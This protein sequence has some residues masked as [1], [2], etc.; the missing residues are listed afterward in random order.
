MNLI[1]SRFLLAII[2]ISMALREHAVCSKTTKNFGSV[3]DGPMSREFNQP[4]DRDNAYPYIDHKQQYGIRF[5][6]NKEIDQKFN[7]EYDDLQLEIDST[8]PISDESDES[9]TD[10]FEAA[11]PVSLTNASMSN[12][13]PSFPVRETLN[14]VRRRFKDWVSRAIGFTAPL[15]GGRGLLSLFNIIAFENSEC[16]STQEANAGV[17]GTCYHDYECAS[18]GGAAIDSC[19]DGLGVCCVCESLYVSSADFRWQAFAAVNVDCGQ[20][21]NRPVSYFQSP[22]WPEASQGR[23]VCTMTIDLQEGVSQL[24]L[25]FVAFEVKID[26]WMPVF[27]S[28]TSRSLLKKLKAPTDGT[29]MDD[30]FVVTGQN[31][32][33]IIPTICGVNTGQHSKW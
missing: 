11:T 19:A 1:K 8:T 12:I 14:F 20:K 30:Q 13:L 6:P 15:V 10:S 29:C 7:H 18:M 9:T 24:R 5:E 27:L 33:N 2:S 26:H 31:V 21:T 25:D 23:I 3:F 28:D 32:N 22:G 16:L 4:F 17:S